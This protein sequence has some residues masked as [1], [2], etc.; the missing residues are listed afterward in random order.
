M[1]PLMTGPACSSMSPERSSSARSSP[2]SSKSGSSS[3][4][5]LAGDSSIVH[6]F[7][8][9]TV[10][11]PESKPA[12]RTSANPSSIVPVDVEGEHP[13]P[14]VPVVRPAVPLAQRVAY[15]AAPQDARHLARALDERVLAPRRHDDVH[16]V[17][18]REAVR[19]ALA[20]D[21]LDGVV[22]VDVL[23]FEAARPA[24]DVVDA[25]EADDAADGVGV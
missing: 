5:I 3:G 23:A 4:S 19:V 18:Q 20:P 7:P 10:M 2:V 22:E 17:E 8:P 12:C 14:V 16:A 6:P 21:E 24:A 9:E 15:P 13:P 25:A 1:T 11:T